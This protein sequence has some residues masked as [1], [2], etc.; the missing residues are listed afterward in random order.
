MR[1]ILLLLLFCASPV[2][3]QSSAPA[4]PVMSPANALQYAIAPFRNAR[5]QI[6]DLTVQDKWAL[7]VSIARAIKLCRQLTPT[8]TLKPNPNLLDLAR[9]CNLG[10][11]YMPA[12]D[13]LIAYLAL[14]HPPHREA[15]Y[16]LLGSVFL[17]LHWPA[18]AESEADTL[19]SDYPYSASTNTLIAKI[20][21]KAEETSSAGNGVV[22][23][24]TQAQLPFL[25]HA[26]QTKTHAASTKA[27][28]KYPPVD[29]AS[30]FSSALRCAYQFRLD[31]KL[32]QEHDLLTELSQ[33]LASA[34]YAHSPDLPVMQ[35]ALQR[36]QTV[37]KLA[38][39][40]ALRG[41]R[42]FTGHLAGPATIDLA[43][44]TTILL[45]VVLWAP[46]SL[47]AVR[48][49]AKS[50]HAIPVTI[51]AVTSYAANTGGADK[52]SA[53]IT[54]ALEDLEKQFPP[55][56]PLLL[57]SDRDLQSVAATS[58]PAAILIGA[59]GK[60][61]YNHST[62][63]TGDLRMLIHAYLGPGQHATPGRKPARS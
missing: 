38:P 10:M 12:R 2:L 53:A 40:T 15:A 16:I 47:A 21:S 44:K 37:G 63:T 18:P 35:S 62:L 22:R 29:P 4:V 31:G 56:I 5:H 58:F 32:K 13:E 51:L 26:L 59:N 46:A 52:P 54:K 20:I 23:R 49:I 39:F 50:Y 55:R 6:N 30:A 3:A 19:M 8:G 17:S 42:I 48:A 1:R 24:L 28:S 34:Q 57:V 45:P 33:T 43:H 7:G 14:P 27:N 41:Q 9:L 61:R 25:L 36:Y 11:Q 60:I